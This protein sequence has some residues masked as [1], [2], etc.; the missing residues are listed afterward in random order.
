VA[1]ASGARRVAEVRLA[2][3][4]DSVATVGWRAFSPDG[5][6]VAFVVVAGG[7]RQIW[8][9]LLA[10]GAPLQVTRDDADHGKPR[11]MP[12]SSA[13]VYYT[14]VA[15]RE[16]GCLWQVSALGGPP[17]RLAEAIGG[18]GASHDG[19]RPTSFRRTGDAV[20]LIVAGLN[21]SQVL[22]VL[23]LPPEFWCALPRW[24][25]DD[26]MIALQRGGDSFD[27][28]L[29]VASIGGGAQRTIVRPD[30][31][32][33]HS[34][35]PAGGGH[36]YGS[37]AGSTMACPPTHNLRTVATDGSNDRQLTFGDGSY[38]DPDVHPSGRL[39]A[40]RARSRSGVR[41][42]PVD[43]APANIW[44]VPMDGGPMRV[45]T[46][47]DDRSVFIARSLSWAPDSRHVYA[48]V[49]D[50]DADVVMLE[51]ILG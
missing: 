25:P 39:L 28:Y 23:T 6:M 8:I 9:R 27:S 34:W 41:R 51:G 12:D 42:F 18:A 22:T 45:V 24:S 38:V 26:R 10:G 29:G 44:I 31:L 35:L 21:G 17:R 11:W 32:L 1:E 47:F 40:S 7:R 5:K 46:D 36:I 20:S 33:G 15:G 16:A 48:A 14:P 2:R 19:K 30:G 3:L 13:L 4:T 37:S 49:A 50:N 43:G